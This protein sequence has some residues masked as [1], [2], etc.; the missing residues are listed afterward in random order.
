M[1][2]SKVLTLAVCFGICTLFIS[3]NAISGDK[4]MKAGTEDAMKTDMVK[5]MKSNKK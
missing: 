4:T 5:P 3:G 2:I 1:K